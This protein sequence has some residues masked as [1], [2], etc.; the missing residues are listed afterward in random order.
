MRI[1]IV[2][3]SRTMR[4]IV[5]RTLAKAGFADA[6]VSEAGNGSEGLSKLAEVAPDVV[7]C[8]WNMPDMDGLD[9]LKRLR[10]LGNTAHFGFITS[11]GGEGIVESAMEAGA[12]FFI[13]KPFTAADLQGALREVIA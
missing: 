1:L 4:R 13:T 8:D 5:A 7:L 3:D 2:D 11:E 9:F 10:E 12:N 6:Q